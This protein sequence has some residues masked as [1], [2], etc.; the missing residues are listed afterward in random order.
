MK[1]SIIIIMQLCICMQSCGMQ[2][3]L[4]DL[5]VLEEKFLAKYQDAACQEKTK[6]K[7]RIV[8]N[9]ED[10]AQRL[11]GKLPTHM[12]DN[13]ALLHFFEYLP[14]I[15]QCYD[16]QQ[17]L[18]LFR[19]NMAD[20]CA[21]CMLQLFDRYHNVFKQPS[22]M[23]ISG[24]H[25]LTPV[26]QLLNR[27]AD[28]PLDAAIEYLGNQ[29]FWLT[30]FK[31][32]DYYNQNLHVDLYEKLSESISKSFSITTLNA[33]QTM[34][35]FLEQFTKRLAVEIERSSDLDKIRF[36][37][38]NGNLAECSFRLDEAL[39]FYN[40]AEE[41]IN[42]T[43]H[44]KSSARKIR[45]GY[46]VLLHTLQC[47]LMNVHRLYGN[48]DSALQYANK[49]ITCKNYKRIGS[50]AKALIWY[51]KAQLCDN[52]KKAQFF[53][54]QT[55]QQLLELYKNIGG[56]KK[57]NEAVSQKEVTQL[58]AY[59]GLTSHAMGEHKRALDYLQQVEGN[60]DVLGADK[61]KMLATRAELL[62]HARNYEKSLQDFQA[63]IDSDAPKQL[64]LKACLN[65]GFILLLN[66]ANDCPDLIKKYFKDV[67]LK[68]S[69]DVGFCAN[70]HAGLAYIYM[71]Q[72]KLDK[73]A[74]HAND[75]LEH[76]IHIAENRHAWVYAHCGKLCILQ[77][78]VDKGV[79]LLK[80]AIQAADNCAL[81]N[82]KGLIIDLAIAYI[83]QG[84][85]EDAK[86]LLSLLQQQEDDNTSY[87]AALLD[88]VLSWIDLCEGFSERQALDYFS[89]QN[90]SLYQTVLSGHYIEPVLWYMYAQYLRT[91]GNDTEAST[92]IE[93]AQ[94]QQRNQFIRF[95]AMLDK[96]YTVLI[97]DKKQALQL[98]KEIIDSSTFCVIT[99]QAK[100]LMVWILYK[101][102]EQI[103]TLAIDL[104][105]G[106]EKIIQHYVYDIVQQHD[107]SFAQLDVEPLYIDLLDDP[108][109]KKERLQTFISHEHI[110]LRR[111]YWA[112]LELAE[113]LFN[114][115]IKTAEA[116]LQEVA[117]Q[118]IDQ[119]LKKEAAQLLIML[120]HNH[121]DIEKQRASES[122]HAIP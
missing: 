43:L 78:N 91:V 3:S 82:K 51:E 76:I 61:Y 21:N 114:Q 92:Y 2:L 10:I 19:S 97:E 35:L 89:F 28:I 119:D 8:G 37:V 121:N 77:N 4:S 93:R 75:A 117:G 34:Q 31:N 105:D 118:N 94:Q 68:A 99:A 15:Y 98:C 20:A 95:K 60:L 108:Q 106:P 6:L 116:L 25:F 11:Q 72:H 63:I 36:A 33:G 71:R 88:T 14:T 55:Y 87:I 109:Q 49:I 110:P 107:N 23:L 54:Q 58:S 38:A 120:Y 1:K 67:L 113:L 59:L 29:D 52:T 17:A 16:D 104:A 42:R 62:H 44:A 122:L 45:V 79:V 81:I 13:R 83:T 5:I 9:A 32:P 84:H 56:L 70:A 74:L 96:A 41:L 103:D 24:K 53:Y 46:K 57:K 86:E 112:Q 100:A 115:E 65:A 22:V 12:P 27:F 85:L 48:L 66:P 102:A 64:R 69:L 7:E 26:Y 80:Q 73:A 50:I 30:L 111:K 101:Y 18:M 47:K 39:Q 40:N 90:F